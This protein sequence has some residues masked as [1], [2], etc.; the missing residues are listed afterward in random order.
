MGVPERNDRPKFD[1]G[2]DATAAAAD[3]VGDVIDNFL[4]VAVDPDCLERLCCRAV[5]ADD[6]RR[7]PQG[8][9]P[10]GDILGINRTIGVDEDATPPH[11]S[12]F[13]HLNQMPV[14]QRFSHSLELDLTKHRELAEN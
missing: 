7:S 4:K 10:L 9:K 14:Q 8:A 13:Q 2:P 12:L 3:Q 6:N 1:T 5:H 11:L